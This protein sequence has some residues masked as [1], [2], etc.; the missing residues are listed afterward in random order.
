MRHASPA[1]CLTALLALAL[2]SCG[3]NAPS[4]DDA[5]KGSSDTKGSPSSSSRIKPAVSV[6]AGTFWLYGEPVASNQNW[7][8]AVQPAE[9]L[10]YLGDEKP[11]D[12]QARTMM[13]K[14]KTLGDKT[15]WAPAYAVAINA[16]PGAVVKTTSTYT[17]RQLTGEIANVKLDALTLVGI[18]AGSDKDGYVEV[19]RG[20]E[21]KTF[22]RSAD[23]TEAETDVFV[24]QKY[25]M[26]VAPA[27]GADRIKL[28]TELL[29]RDEVKSSI[30]RA[31]L[32]AELQDLKTGTTTT[33]TTTTTTRPAPR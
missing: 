6:Y 28:L 10:E 22:M 17:S 13:Y 25:Q 20:W 4:K 2:L 24:A 12:D 19:Q 16:K 32:A 27:K 11:L 7:V 9:K 21:P 33:T 18:Y 30:F 31:R 8:V 29:A 5:S 1:L 14:V 15:G 26:T 3:D 23:L